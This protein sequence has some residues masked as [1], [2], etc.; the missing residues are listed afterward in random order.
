MIL[1]C[2]KWLWCNLLL[3]S[4]PHCSQSY[5]NFFLVRFWLV[6]KLGEGSHIQIFTLALSFFR[7]EKKLRSVRP[8]VAARGYRNLKNR[9]NKALC[10]DR[11][12][13]PISCLFS[14][15]VVKEQYI[16]VR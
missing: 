11:H 7:R 15:S 14:T 13:I 10:N 3:Y 6:L 4:A 8:R 5:S 1:I 9:L 16:D 2:F 12:P